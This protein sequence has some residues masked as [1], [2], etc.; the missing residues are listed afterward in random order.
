MI[1]PRFARAGGFASG[2]AVVSPPDAD[3]L[4]GLIDTTGKLIVPAVWRDIKC[5]NG[6]LFQ[7]EST[8]GKLGLIDE[9]GGE[10]L[11]RPQGRL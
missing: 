11:R 9:V 1:E 3:G 5:F 8:D 10:E 2:R 7:V 6:N 4:F